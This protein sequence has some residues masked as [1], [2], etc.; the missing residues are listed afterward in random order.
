[1]L[2]AQITRLVAM[3]ER[4]EWESWAVVM[5]GR[6]GAADARYVMAVQRWQA[7]KDV[8]AQVVFEGDKLRREVGAWLHQAREFYERFKPRNAAE[9]AQREAR[10]QVIG[11]ALGALEGVGEGSQIR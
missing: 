5:D 2:E 4:M 10:L 9:R 7:C 1:M 8:R 6:V 11:E 3:L